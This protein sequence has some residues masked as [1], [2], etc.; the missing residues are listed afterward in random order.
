MMLLFSCAEGVAGREKGGDEM[1]DELGN[2]ARRPPDS[3][4]RLPDMVELGGSLGS[5]GQ[6]N[7]E[8]NRAS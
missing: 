3:G 6:T 2:E 1:S 5:R 7:L 8:I 4:S